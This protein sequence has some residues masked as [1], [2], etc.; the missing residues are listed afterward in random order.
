MN[1]ALLRL[2]DRVPVADLRYFVIAVMIQRESGGNLAELLDNIATIVR[3]RLKLLGEV[4]T[5]SAEGRL[6]AWILIALPFCVTAAIINIVNSEVHERP[7]D[8][9]GRPQARRRALFDDGTSVWCGCARSSASASEGR[10]NGDMCMLQIGFLA[11]VFVAHLRAGHL[12]AGL[13]PLAALQ[14]D[15]C[16]ASR[17]PRG[18]RVRR[19]GRGMGRPGG[20]RDQAAGKLS[21][22]EAG[23]E[24]SALRRRL[25]NAGM[26]SPT[27][28]MAFFG[29]KTA[30]RW[31]CRCSRSRR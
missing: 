7:V 25:V 10:E 1:E 9:P 19:C 18:Q 26:R 22:P 3:A 16:A 8:R 4:R 31:D 13:G 27:A 30:W 28:P 12:G 15:G 20:P 6:S 2:A 21:A 11:L 24:S 23:Y 17:R 29:A 14:A 5:L